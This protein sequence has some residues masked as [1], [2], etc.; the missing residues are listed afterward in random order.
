MNRSHTVLIVVALLLVCAG[1]AQANGIDPVIIVRGGSGSIDITSLGTINLTFPGHVGCISGAY[2]ADPWPPSPAMQQFIGL[3]SMTCV[4]KNVT[5]SQISALTFNITS[6]TN[7]TLTLVCDLLCSSTPTAN[8]LLAT[9][10]LNP[11]VPGLPANI[12]YREFA[13]DFI[14]FDPGTT[15]A[16]T[17]VPEPG[18]WALLAMGL[19]ALITR[20]RK[21]K[22]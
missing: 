1:S 11:P 13:I 17:F 15:I 9:F 2:P 10:I 14:N 22:A 19:G 5:T 4:F 6:Q 16:T 18:T 12:F 21:A 20:R 3:Q 7:P 8:G